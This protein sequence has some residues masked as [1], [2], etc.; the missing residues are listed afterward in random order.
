MKPSI[1]PYLRPSLVIL[2]NML[3]PI[4]SV[5]VSCWTYLCASSSIICTENL[6]RDSVLAVNSKNNL[7]NILVKHLANLSSIND[8]L[9]STNWTG[10]IPSVVEKNFWIY[11]SLEI[12]SSP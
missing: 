9:I 3:Y 8:K 11:C 7:E 5:S 2:S 6:P 12:Y 10:S 1:V 4:T